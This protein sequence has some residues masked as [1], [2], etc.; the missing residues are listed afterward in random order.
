MTVHEHLRHC[1][2][3]LWLVWSCGASG[4]TIFDA[5]ELHAMRP[6]RYK[7]SLLAPGTSAFHGTRWLVVERE[8]PR[9]VPGRSEQTDGWTICVRTTSRWMLRWLPVNVM[10]HQEKRLCLEAN[11]T[12]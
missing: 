2:D 5:I 9:G 6:R 12:F 8:K 11:C 4:K 10:V 7:G 3:A 1:I